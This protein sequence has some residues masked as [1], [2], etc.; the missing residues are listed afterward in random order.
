MADHRL[1]LIVIDTF[2]SLGSGRRLAPHQR[3]EE[4][5]V[6]AHGLRALAR[7]SKVPILVVARLSRDADNRENQM[8]ILPDLSESGS[9]DQ[10]A[11]LVGLLYRVAYHAEDEKG[12]AERG[13][14]KAELI[15]AKNSLGPLGSVPL[16][17][18]SEFTRF[19]SR[20]F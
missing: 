18:Q 9:L 17:F 7:E 5:S 14:D 8:P 16:T 15:I 1:G 19:E 11:D 20:A 10:E 3:T 13:G 12:R 4:M 6:I 2:E